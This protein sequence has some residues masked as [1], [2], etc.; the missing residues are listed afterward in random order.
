MRCEVSEAGYR[1][2]GTVRRA[3]D[4]RRVGHLRAAAGGGAL[5]LVE[6]DLV[7]SPQGVWDAAAEGCELVCHVASPFDT[8]SHSRD[9]FLG[10]AVG[11]TEKVL[12]AAA[13][14]GA[15]RV[16]VTSSCAAVSE[17]F[18]K[19]ES[20]GRTF[21]AGDWSREAQC[22][23]YSLSKIVAERRAR[24]LAK[25]GDEELEGAPQL[26]TVNPSYVQG[27]AL[28]GR[29]DYASL[30]LVREL[31]AGKVPALARMSLNV[32]HI[33]D[34][35]AIH[36]AALTRG[37]SGGRYIVDGGPVWM[38]SVASWLRD[39][40]AP[41]GFTKVPSLVAPSFVVKIIALCDSN[42]ASVAG[43]LDCEKFHDSSPAEALLGR[44]LRR[45]REAIMDAAEACVQ[46]GLVTPTTQARQ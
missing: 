46:G 4:A 8:G 5:E 35:A 40:Y 15:R 33:D 16:C 2:R 32:C 20:R 10:A 3:S 6:A 19:A 31:L 9:F 18:G 28:S 38:T 7:E 21:S 1:V 37:E 25:G 44:P 45:P 23:P 13:K 26:V 22:Q 36:V 39:E 43:R 14:A 12:R 27:G 42:A 41:K 11:G 30:A 24:A 17:G 34:V 29:K